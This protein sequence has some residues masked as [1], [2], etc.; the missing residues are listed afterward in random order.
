MRTLRFIHRWLGILLALP[1]VAL[2]LSGAILTLE[3]VWPSRDGAPLASGQPASANAILATAQAATPPGMRAARYAPPAAPGKAA[4]VFFAPADGPRGP[5]M[6]LRLDPATAAALGPVEPTGGVLDWIKRLHNNL[7]IPEWGGRQ[8]AGWFGV[9]LLLLTLIGI[10]LWWPGP[11]QWRGGFTV[12]RQARGLRLHRA[13]HGAAGI[14]LVVMLLATS[15]TGIAMG[16]PQTTR[17]LLGLPA[18]GP[19]RPGRPVPGV[20]PPAPD[21]DAAIRLAQA[22]MP[23]A[24]PHAVLLP[25]TTQEPIRL[26]MAPPGQEGAIVTRVV[27]VD[28]AATRMLSTQTSLPASDMA[29]RWAHDLHEG[30]GLG[31]IWRGLTV[32]VG[33]ALSLF[34]VTG[35][36]MWLLR[37]RNRRRLEAMRQA[38]VRVEAAAVR[39]EA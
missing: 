31:P 13:L 27:A 16:F 3:P 25:A 5:G 14:W 32:A 22:A 39:V 33:L 29:W 36:A 7:L 21:L 9:G 15:G 6:V 26:M 12:P 10:P 11:G 38:A 2:G 35:F 17:S 34:G 20:S 24:V 8:I 28:G 23:G 19:Q 4:Q 37:R 1:L 18:G 30:Q